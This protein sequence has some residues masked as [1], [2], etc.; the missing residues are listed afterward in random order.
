MDFQF[1]LTWCNNWWHGCIGQRKFGIPFLL[2]GNFR[3]SI[4]DA[5]YQ[6]SKNRFV[7]REIRFD[8]SPGVWHSRLCAAAL[9]GE[10]CLGWDQWLEIV[11]SP[12]S[13]YPTS[14]G[15]GQSREPPWMGS[16]LGWH[17]IW[18]AA[19]HL[20]SAPPFEVSWNLGC[21]M[22]PAQYLLALERKCEWP[23]HLIPSKVIRQNEDDVGRIFVVSLNR[24]PFPTFPA[25][26]SFSLVWDW[27]REEKK[28]QN[29]I[30]FHVLCGSKIL[31]GWTKVT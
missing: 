8:S 9:A 1:W 24:V 19:H 28:Q 16:T 13:E 10:P 29:E 18:K 20:C 14:K 2:G 11:Q 3:C 15:R 6:P 30:I 25:F 27:D 21:A 7:Q 5:I 12:L 17:R 23:Y 4:Q 22:I 31:V 26:P